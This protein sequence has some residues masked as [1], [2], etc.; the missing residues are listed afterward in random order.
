VEFVGHPLID[1]I[2]PSAGRAE[3][4]A[5]LGLTPGAPTIAVLPGS[6][7]NEVRRILPDLAAA[8]RLIGGRVPGTQFVFARAPH[9]DDHLF[10][11]AHRLSDPASPGGA[12][13]R[14]AIV[15]GESDAVLAAA[16]VALVASGTATVQAALHDTPMVV[17]YRLSPLTY[18]VGRP[19][20]KVD[21]F[22]MVNLIAGERVVPEL[23]QD[24]FTPAAV[25]GEA[26]AMLTDPARAA[27]IRDGLR[28]VRTRLGGSGASRRAA[29]AILQV[30]TTH[31]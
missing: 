17:V 30:A 1:L 11:P 7:P 31:A 27:G 26:V 9:L 23:I 4:L 22:A 21:T 28:R 25:A 18:R 13:L 3:F 12:T 14:T 10:E 20:V 15:E 19:L 16:D 2:A 6:R 24:A 5:R 8:A 29:E